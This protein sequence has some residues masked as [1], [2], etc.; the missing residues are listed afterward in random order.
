MRAV[1]MRQVGVP[2]EVEDIRD[3]HPS[4]GE[5]LVKVAATGVCH[6]DLHVLKGDLPFP[7]PCVLG[8][9][10]S[11]IVAEIG[12]GVTN[13]TVGERV[14]SPFIM[15]CGFC[16]FCVRGEEELCSTWFS[17][18][19]G[20]GGLFDGT[21]RLASHDGSPISMYSMAGFA[22][23][24][25]V[26]DTS[27]FHVPD[28]L[29]LEDCAVLGCAMFTAFGLLRNTA[30]LGVGETV[31]IV[32]TG[33]VGSAAIQL[34]GVFGASRVIAIDIRDDKLEAAREL[35]AT[36]LV[37]AAKADVGQAVRELTGGIGVD[38]AIEA[39]GHSSTFESALQSVRPGGRV[40]LVGLA[41]SGTEAHFEITPFVRRKISILGSFG[42]RARTD[43]PLLLALAASGRIDPGRFISR[44]YP[45]EQAAA[46]FE[47][48][49]RGEVIGRSIIVGKDAA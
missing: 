4:R 47:A 36:D 17:Q 35:G 6:S 37:N 9:E 29:V 3:P 44:R 33:G 32:G 10:I 11:G 12:E 22:E 41:P 14:A 7:L 48:L 31:A 49:E 20:K 2:P 15:P 46:A 42:G 45:L 13:V 19:R 1:V 43:M 40:A 39:F 18:N 28:A 8:H 38:V 30:K 23:Y 21:S 24:S 5:V 25:V 27:V 26:P 16:A 34:A